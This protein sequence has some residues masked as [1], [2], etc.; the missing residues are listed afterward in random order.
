MGNEGDLRE[1]VLLSRHSKEALDP[2]KHVRQ[3]HDTAAV[4]LLCADAAACVRVTI[5]SWME[6]PPLTNTQSRLVT[7]RKS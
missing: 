4:F 2:D 5:L 1:E 7:L 3:P 6:D